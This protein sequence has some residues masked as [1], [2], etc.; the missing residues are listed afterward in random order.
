MYAY[1]APGERRLPG[2]AE[3]PT[4]STAMLCCS[5]FAATV[6]RRSGR[7]VDGV[8]TLKPKSSLFAGWLADGK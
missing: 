1:L 3:V 6:R 4:G 7:L 8:A 2:A 5:A